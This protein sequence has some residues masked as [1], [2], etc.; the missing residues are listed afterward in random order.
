MFFQEF[1]CEAVI[2]RQLTHQNILPF[3]GVYRLDR[4]PPRVCFVCPWMENGNLVSYLSERAPA[5]NCV[6]IVSQWRH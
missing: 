3:Y 4:N 6:P 1:S 2:W 5:T